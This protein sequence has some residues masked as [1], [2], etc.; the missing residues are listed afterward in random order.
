[1]SNA[2]ERPVLWCAR[3]YAGEYLQDNSRLALLSSQSGEAE[4][5]SVRQLLSTPV[6]C[7]LTAMLIG[8]SEAARYYFPL[9]PVAEPYPR[10][11]L[12]VDRVVNSWS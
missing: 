9:E 1:M 12:F 10:M 2:D 6:E 8:L 4:L 11:T 7:H 5:R 3:V